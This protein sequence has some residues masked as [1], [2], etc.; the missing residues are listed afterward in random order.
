MILYNTAMGVAA[1]LALLTLLRFWNRVRQMQP[2]AQA[3]AALAEQAAP[4]VGE[5]VEAPQRAGVALATR[6]QTVSRMPSVADFEPAD[7]APTFFVLGALLGGLGA[8]MSMSHPLTANP[9]INIAFGEPCLW[10]GLLLL[11]AA[12]H[13]WRGGKLSAGA[14]R[15]ISPVVVAVGLILTFCAA[16]IARFNL[17]GAAPAEEP[18]TGLLHDYPLVENTFFFTLYALAAI[19]ALVFPRVVSGASDLAWAVMRGCWSVAGIGF[20]LFSA[21]NYYTH[22]GMMIN[23]ARPG[24]DYS[25]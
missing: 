6:Q 25:F 1:G 5:L 4:G 23:F 2:T 18:I 15:A 10:L 19:G 21:M 20:V 12:I 13:L 14:L 8:A 3:A 17:V 11:A 24:A 7:Y 22:I 16:A 9:P